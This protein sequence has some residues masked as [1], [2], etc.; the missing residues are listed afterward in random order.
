MKK[1]YQGCSLFQRPKNID[2]GRGGSIISPIILNFLEGLGISVYLT[3]SQK[4]EVNGGPER[5]HSII[6][7]TVSS[8]NVRNC[9]P[10]LLYLLSF[11]DHQKTVDLFFN[12][13]I[14]KLNVQ[15]KYG[16]FRKQKN[17]K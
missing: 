16:V 1:N 4:G 5:F 12:D 2:L 8:M 3:S 10:L 6:L 17:Q 9:L 11:G 14:T 13:F 15:M 7:E